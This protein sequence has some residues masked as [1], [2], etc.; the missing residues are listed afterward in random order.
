MIN[1]AC[2]VA[3]GFFDGVHIAHQEIIQT[4][5]D[6]AKQNNLT[7][8]ALTFDTAPAEILR[9]NAAR[10]LTGNDEKVRLI[11]A[12]GANTEFLKT[13]KTLL[14][15]SAEDFIL[16]ILVKKYNVKYAVCGYNY[17]FG[18]GGMGDVELLKSYGEKY[19]FKTQIVAPIECG[20]ES[21]SSSRIRKLL[22]DGNVKEANLL[23][24]RNFSLRGR[25]S[26]GK[27]L[28]RKIGF[29]TANVFYDGSCAMVKKG[30]YKTVVNID[31]AT[32]KAITNI[33]INPTI[34]GEIPRSET[35]IPSFCENLYGR[36]IEIEFID[37]IRP[38][39]KF[40]NI[41]M[42]KNQIQKDIQEI[43]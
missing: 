34:G 25:V 35:Y 29:P 17:R 2:V 43:L 33:G 21:I 24:G 23:L 38:E 6:Y 18:K 5:V 22:L 20:G 36:E 12:L 19:G 27:R 9:P 40:E 7:P 30:V 31:S 42:L 1:T 32:Y 8:I 4:A 39:I 10:Y 41:E 14:D 11:N 15:M 28:G 26:E 16:E 13:D 37:F 3:L